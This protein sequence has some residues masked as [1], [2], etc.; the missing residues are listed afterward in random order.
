MWSFTFW[1]DGIARDSV[2]VV[3]VLIVRNAL[4][5]R[6]ACVSFSDATSRDMTPGEVSIPIRPA[7]SFWQP[8]P[9]LILTAAP[10][11]SP[12]VAR[13]GLL[14]FIV[15]QFLDEGKAKWVDVEQARAYRG[16]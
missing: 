4:T 12:R 11:A 2:D 9:A 8:G 1:E 16:L 5:N 7:L 14:A 10:R 15:A 13:I 3:S 6:G